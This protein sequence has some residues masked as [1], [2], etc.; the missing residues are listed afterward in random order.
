MEPTE[1]MT[2]MAEHTSSSN[3]P[4]RG[5]LSVGERKRIGDELHDGLAQDLAGV[6]LLAGGFVGKLPDGVGALRIE[7]T[8]VQDIL[9]QSITRCRLLAYAVCSDIK[10]RR[11]S[12]RGS[13]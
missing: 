5:T 10:D 12:Q 11:P 4:R 13:A 1:W 6:S 7:L 8:Q 3:R 2:M 9:S